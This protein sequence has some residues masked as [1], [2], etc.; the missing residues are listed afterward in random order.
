[1]AQTPSIDRAAL[2]RNVRSVVIKI[3]TNALS[4][5]AGRLDTGL[6][7][8]VAEQVTALVARK[9]QVTLVSSGAIGAGISEL[10]LPGRPKNL[11]M[12]QAAASVGQSIL[13]RLFA[14]AFRPLGLHAGQI[15]IT[16]SDFD[17]R[18]RYLNLRNCI[19]ALHA[20]KCVPI[21]NEND[22]VA[23]AE[24]R[25]G[26][27]DLIAA[28]VTNLLLAD[29]LILLSVVDG[30]LDAEGKTIPLIQDVDDASG[31]VDASMKSTGGS[32]GM[33][34]KLFAAGTVKTAGEPVLIAN[35]KRPNIIR[36][37]LAGEP[38]GTLIVP[39]SKKLSARSRWIGLTARTRGTLIVDDGAA[40][41][42]RQNKSLLASGI[43]SSEGDFERGHAV[44]ITG[45]DGKLIARGLINYS[46]EDVETIR[47]H[48]S[49]EFPAL[50]KTDTYYEEV[51]HRDNLFLE[52]AP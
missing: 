30:L 10:G 2:L 26:D 28:H 36:D 15:L 50:L 51:I 12:L 22:S 32:G 11:P 48:K 4:D 40:N 38:I 14:D 16:R 23:V 5:A 42:L 9:V 1:M 18:A 37:L 31:H 46:R 35:G 24:I 52:T 43:L 8:H 13:M 29:L 47:G 20:S 7:A 3:G 39:T 34:A 21:I 6:I 25:F 41:A 27:N 49:S 17:E 19:H 45:K 33:G 44:Q